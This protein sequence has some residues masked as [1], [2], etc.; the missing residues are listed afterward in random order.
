MSPRTA[1]LLAFLLLPVLALPTSDSPKP[2]EVVPRP[3]TDRYGDPLPPG[4]VAR[5]GTVR[6]HKHCAMRGATFSPDGRYVATCGDCI[7]LWDRWT[8]RLLRSLRDDEVEQV[9]G[10]Y[11]FA[12]T[13]DG[14]GVV[15]CG[16]KLV[17]FWDLNSG[18]LIRRVA[19]PARLEE[20]VIRGDLA[21]S[22]DGTTCACSDGK[23]VLVWDTARGQARLEL[24]RSETEAE[25][26]DLA[27]TRDGRELA[28]LDASGCLTVVGSAT[29]ER[30]RRFEVG[31][32]NL[33]LAPDAGWVA[34]VTEAEVA[35]WDV[36]DGRKKSLFRRDG[37]DTNYHVSLCPD[38]RTLVAHELCRGAWSCGTWAPRNSCGDSPFPRRNTSRPW[39]SPR[40]ASR[41]RGLMTRSCACGMP[42]TGDRSWTS[43]AT[44]LRRLR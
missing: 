9:R 37:Q 36:T 5:L 27:L 12:F 41:W 7:H 31:T 29:G 10:Y 21:L 34:A 6:L 38:G 30:L 25:V 32:G 3:R 11:C 26:S 28:I 35:V 39:P 17:R 40:T 22:L 18:Q 15:A 19:W 4:A 2:A 23:R 14:R 42:P 16:S 43:R 33:T 44:P 13:P 20:F 24:T 1:S 8:G